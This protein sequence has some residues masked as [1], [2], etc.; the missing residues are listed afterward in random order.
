MSS[1]LSDEPIFSVTTGISEKIRSRE[2][3]LR[4]K[5]VLQVF[6]FFLAFKTDL[7]EPLPVKCSL[8]RYIMLPFSKMFY[9]PNGFITK[10]I[11]K[12][13]MTFYASNFNDFM[14]EAK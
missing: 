3:T 13:E 2:M 14:H 5:N 6:Q 7:N 8:K 4:N 12:I 10:V 9:A 11:R 1:G